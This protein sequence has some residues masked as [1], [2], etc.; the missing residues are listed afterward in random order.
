[1]RNFGV[2]VLCPTIMSPSVG[3]HCSI[4]V[5]IRLFKTVDDTFVRLWSDRQYDECLT[6]YEQRQTQIS[7]AVPLHLH[8]TKA[9][10][11]EIRVTQ[12]WLKATTWQ[13]C[14]SK[15]LVDNASSHPSMT[16]MYP[17]IIFRDLLEVI[18]RLSEVALGATHT[19]L[20]S[21]HALMFKDS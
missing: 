15:G 16:S 8:C 12:L 5:R 7:E 3:E 19:E 17:V 2:V 6:W 10:E 21:H 14:V 20:V 18:H 13:L 9:Q 1:M 11:F 4:E